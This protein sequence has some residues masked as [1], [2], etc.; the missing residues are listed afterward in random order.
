M[1]PRSSGRPAALAPLALILGAALTACGSD[2]KEADNA[3]SGS[4]DRK[5]EVALTDAG[6]EP[7]KLQLAAGAVTF[8]VTKRAPARSPSSR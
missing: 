2:G 3:G 8:N 6:C 7:A 1:N 5:V 4:G